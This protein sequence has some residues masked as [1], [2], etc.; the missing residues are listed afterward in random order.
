MHEDDVI[1]DQFARIPASDKK[2]DVLL[3]EPIV[4][5]RPKTW[6]HAYIPHYFELEKETNRISVAIKSKWVDHII[7][8]TKATLSAVKY[9][10][11]GM[12][13]AF[14]M[15]LPPSRGAACAN[16]KR[17]YFID[18]DEIRAE[19]LANFLSTLRDVPDD[20][21]PKVVFSASSEVSTRLFASIGDMI[22][23][24]RR[25][26]KVIKNVT[27]EHKSPYSEDYFDLMAYGSL[28]EAAKLDI[29]L[30]DENAPWEQIRESIIKFHHRNYALDRLQDG[31]SKRHFSQIQ[32]LES[33]IRKQLQTS[34]GDQGA[35]LIAALAQVLI[36]R[37]L[38]EDDAP[39]TTFRLHQL[40][41]ATKNSFL[42]AQCD[43]FSNQ[44][45]GV[46]SYALS[47]LT[48]ASL[49]LQSKARSVTEHKLY[50]LEYLAT[51]QNIFVT[52]FYRPRTFIDLGEANAIAAFADEEVPHFSE[53]GMLKNAVGLSHLF[54]GSIYCAIDC[55]TEASNHNANTL[56]HLNICINLMIAKKIAG[57][58]PSAAEIE[59]IFTRYI[60]I[61][62]TSSSSY[63]HVRALA[64]LIALCANKDISSSIRDHLIKARYME[65]SEN[66]VKNNQLIS[67]INENGHL[68]IDR[69]SVTGEYG[70]FISSHGL[71]PAPH[72]NW[73]TASWI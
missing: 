66:D 33:Y 21:R 44:T 37:I 34:R 23:L 49:T 52:R 29:M 64:N 24:Y 38:V 54:A 48:N 53:M 57:E 13:G 59:R 69:R 56:T 46:S 62:H 39:N 71:L 50:T 19:H 58:V 55:L 1:Y 31:F 17:L 22:T 60:Q 9:T 2:I 15:S 12:S 51:M 20:I 4:G 26:S 73:T 40:A 11:E 10:P 61:Q 28:E 42:K 14:S 27:L 32:Q 6:D 36:H 68:F 35:F 7:N 67:F 63:H 25:T 5:P 45:Q 65:Y 8:A 72:F 41:D 47:T 16:L 3:Q 18:R 30:A 70:S 43:R